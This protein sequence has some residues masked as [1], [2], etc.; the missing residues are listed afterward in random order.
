MLG[1]GLLRKNPL[2]QVLQR[3]G[4]LGVNNF[5]V[6]FGAVFQLDL[7][8][9]GEVQDELFFTL[10]L[11]LVFGGDLFVRRTLFGLVEGV[12][13]EAIIFLGKRL[14]AVLTA[15]AC[16]SV[17]ETAGDALHAAAAI[18][19]LHNFTLVHDDVMDHAPLRRNRKTVHVR[20]N[21][22]TAIL[23]G[24]NMIALAYASL[25]RSRANRLTEISRTFTQAFINVCE[26]QGL[27][28]EFEERGDI[29][30]DDYLFMIRRKTASIIS[31]AAEIGGL[32]G[33]ADKHQQKALRMFGE[34][35]G[36]AFQMNDD[37]LDVIGTP[38][39]F[40]KAIGGDIAEGKKTVLLLHALESATGKD[41]AILRSLRPGRKISAGMIEDVRRLYTTTGAVDRARAGIARMTRTAKRS[42]ASLP[43]NKGKRMLSWLADELL[44]RAN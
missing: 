3:L 44:E 15:I 17:G 22:N 16:E 40:G 18:E 8:A 9:G 34:H 35:L 30:M 23:I 24:D 29:T 36:M 28:K 41:R 13:L 10:R 38:E 6:L 21:T 11:A 32:C 5:V 31:A 7:G 1:C 19:I 37:L 12:A 42:L 39:K 20:W 26:G 33:N 25:L 2:G 14:R 27:D 4:I 43:D